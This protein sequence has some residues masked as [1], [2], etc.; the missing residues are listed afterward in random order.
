M[1]DWFENQF[2]TDKSNAAD[3][4]QITLDKEGRYT[5]LEIYLHYLVKDNIAAQCAGGSYEAVK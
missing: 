5:N 3:G 4:N 2:G 1:P